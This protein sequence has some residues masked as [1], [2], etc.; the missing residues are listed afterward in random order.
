MD[1]FK[2]IYML[3][4]M[5]EIKKFSR[6]MIKRATKEYE[7][8]AEHL[9]LLSQ[10]SVKKEKMTPMTLSQTMGVSKTIISRIIDQLNKKGYVEKI[11]DEKDKRSYYVS[12]T[13][14]GKEQI[15]KIYIHYL[16][17]IYELERRLGEEAF[18]ELMTC[19]EEANIVMNEPKEE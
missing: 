8:P 6:V 4:R 14:E 16:S 1:E 9:D 3:E 13:E 19:I 7:I 15:N 17:P 18:Y 10:L 5:Q 11:K 2:W 12:I